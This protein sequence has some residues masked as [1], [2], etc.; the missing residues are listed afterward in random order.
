MCFATVVWDMLKG[1]LQKVQDSRSG[2]AAKAFMREWPA[3][4]AM[5]YLVNT[6]AY[7]PRPQSTTKV[8]GTSAAAGQTSPAVQE[9]ETNWPIAAP[10]LARHTELRHYYTSSDAASS[11]T[12]PGSACKYNRP[13]Y[14]TYIG[15]TGMY[16]GSYQF[17][18][19][20]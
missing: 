4:S 10:C 20:L 8:A 16:F 12:A 6:T 19:R 14:R 7:G 1:R 2:C 9:F 18:P 15:P 17:R 3:I 5:P 11:G 13:V